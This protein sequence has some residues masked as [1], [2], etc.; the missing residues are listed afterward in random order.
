M[1]Q[2]VAISAFSGVDQKRPPS[3][4]DAGTNQSS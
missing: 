2:S 4:D 3:L 1:G